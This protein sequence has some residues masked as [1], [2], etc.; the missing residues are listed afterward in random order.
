MCA[1]IK[2]LGMSRGYRGEHGEFLCDGIK[3]LEEAVKSGAEILNVLTS[4][5]I[6]FPLPIDTRVYHADRGIIDSISPLKNP[7]DTLF[8]C[9]IP[10]SNTFLNFDET[11]ILLD[12][13]QDP[14]NIG[15]IVRT[16][17]ALG[18]GGVILTGQC[19]DPYNPKTLRAAMGAVFRQEFKHMDIDELLT[20]RSNGVRFIGAVAGGNCRSLSEVCLAGAVIA[21]GNEGRGLSQEILGLCCDKVT[22]PI[23]AECESL[24]AAAAAA[25]LMWEATR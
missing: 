18:V 10:T 22:I 9:K 13:V 12:S 5:D 6:P 2:K 8:T 16:A 3:L 20:L 24:N 23:A 15:A 1:H 4:S 11:H 14:G 17:N 21:I 25:I 19:A 7:Q